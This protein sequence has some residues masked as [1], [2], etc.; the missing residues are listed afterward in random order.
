MVTLESPSGILAFI[1]P[2]SLPLK[3]VSCWHLNLILALT[4]VLIVDQEEI[5]QIDLKIRDNHKEKEGIKRALAEIEE[6]LDT[7]FAQFNKAKREKEAINEEKA[8]KAAE[9]RQW[10][11]RCASIGRQS[12]STHI[13]RMLTR[14]IVA[15]D[16][17]ALADLENK[18]FREDL[19]RSEAK[20]KDMLVRRT[21]EALR[22]V[23]SEQVGQRECFIH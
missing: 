9:Y 8:A 11:V 7:L 23:V 4:K 14:G 12:N 18:N 16:R 3:G 6:E 1:S 2:N 21:E 17:T 22:F 13:R 20:L 5:R 10:E 15:N 19:E